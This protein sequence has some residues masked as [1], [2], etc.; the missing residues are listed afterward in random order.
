MLDSE[1]EEHQIHHI[2][3]D[4]IVSV[5][6]FACGLDQLLLVQNLFIRPIWDAK[7]CEDVTEDVS[8]ELIERLNLSIARFVEMLEKQIEVGAEGD[9]RCL[10]NSVEHPHSI[11]I[12][13]QTISKHSCSLVSPKTHHLVGLCQF[14][15][16]RQADSLDDLREISQVE[17]VVRLSRSRLHILLNLLI[18][19]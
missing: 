9:F 8:T 18:D 3:S 6:S 4:L 19:T 5:K 11:I 17:R 13:N 15:L 10:L 14:I 12:V 7:R 2:V 1:V 16:P